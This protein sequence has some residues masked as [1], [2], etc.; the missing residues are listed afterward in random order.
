MKYYMFIYNVKSK[1]SMFITLFCIAET[2]IRRR[3]NNINL[4]FKT[5]LK[6]GATIYKVTANNVSTKYPT[7]SFRLK[8]DPDSEA[9]IR[10]PLYAETRARN[11]FTERLGLMEKV[12]STCVTPLLAGNSAGKPAERKLCGK[13]SHRPKSSQN[14]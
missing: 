7:L 9:D 3:S 10:T 14:C 5:T 6:Y 2:K 11:T 13:L 1:I 12:P 8:N 4:S